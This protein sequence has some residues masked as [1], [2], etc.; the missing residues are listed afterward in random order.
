MQNSNKP[1]QRKIFDALVSYSPVL[2]L[3]TYVIMMITETSY[4]YCVTESY[5]E[6]TRVSTFIMAVTMAFWFV[7]NSTTAR[8][9]LITKIKPVVIIVSLM[10]N[11]TL[12]IIMIFFQLDCSAYV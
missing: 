7:P 12:R 2:L 5:I 6:L 3:V 4:R 1:T 8:R 9:S 10:A 11:I